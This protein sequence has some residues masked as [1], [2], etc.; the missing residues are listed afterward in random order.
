M[1][2]NPITITIGLLLLLIF[3]LLLFFYQVRTTEVALLTTFGKPTK[4]VTEPRA[5]V[6]LPWPIQ[7]VHK[8]DKRIHNFE[9]KFEQ[10]FTSDGHS[11]LI[12]VYAGWNIAQPQVFFPRFGDSVSRLEEAL[13]GIVRNAYSGVVG[14]HPFSHFIS[15]DEK[16]LKFEQIETE[17]LE[18]IQKDV[19]ANGYGVEVKFV[20]I[21]RIGLPES[22]T[23]LV[24]ERMQAE[25]QLQVRRIESEGQRDASDIR[26]AANLAS[27]KVISEAEAEATRIRG[28][29]DK[30]AAASLQV[31]QQEPELANFL[32]Q[33]RA[34]EDFLKER[35]TLI[36]DT[37]TFPLNLLNGNTSAPAAP[38]ISSTTPK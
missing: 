5:Y 33:L 25:R 4:T 37:Q 11:L 19:S 30:Q 8:F 17:I 35:T 28:E 32:I 10:V 14:S 9:S 3:G 23:K 24:F 6:K 1:K 2:R 18:R 36:L 29:G 12:K 27:A 21:K 26:S 20:G 22:V 16:Q 13:E 38:K 34:L 15:T 7:Q 31:F